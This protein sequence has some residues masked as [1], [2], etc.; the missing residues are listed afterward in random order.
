MR[1]L[2]I[3][4]VFPGYAGMVPVIWRETGISDCRSGKWVRFPRPAFLSTEDEDFDSFAA[5]Y[6]EELERNCTE[7]Q[8][9]TVWTP[10]MKEEIRK[11]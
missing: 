11:E 7:K 5:M 8:S 10:F 6:Y 1:E 4:P 3:E 2:G 9:I